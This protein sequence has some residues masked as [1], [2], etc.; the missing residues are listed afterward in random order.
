MIARN[1]TGIPPVSRNL[2][3]EQFWGREKKENRKNLRSRKSNS[4]E[5]R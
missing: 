2:A 1:G 3:I 5:E 4:E